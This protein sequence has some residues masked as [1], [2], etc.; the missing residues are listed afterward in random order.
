M[1]FKAT[2]R[3]PLYNEQYNSFLFVL[4]IVFV[5]AD[6]EFLAKNKFENII[7]ASYA[8]VTSI[9]NLEEFDGDIANAFEVERENPKNIMITQINLIKTLKLE[10]VKFDNLIVSK[11]SSI[12]S[13][14]AGSLET[15]PSQWV[16]NDDYSPKFVAR[17]KDK[18]PE[19]TKIYDDYFKMYW[20]HD[21][22]SIQQL[23]DFKKM[24]ELAFNLGKTDKNCD[25]IFTNI[26]QIMS[27]NPQITHTNTVSYLY[28][29]YKTGC[30]ETIYIEEKK[31][32]K[33][34]NF[35]KKIFN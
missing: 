1:M 24:G 15:V 6:N 29:C 14:Y 11:Y 35:I 33:L 7:I 13:Y 23:K 25:S 26:K 30:G 34:D 10:V 28:S 18:H 8:K 22:L 5:I 2:L 32:S 9:Q 20:N 16:G 19:I 31:E 21:N 27:D 17:S 12:P 3:L 4:R